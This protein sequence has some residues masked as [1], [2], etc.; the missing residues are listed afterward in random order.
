MSKNE[1]SQTQAG[2]LRAM[3]YNTLYRRDIPKKGMIAYM[4]N[5][6]G[7]RQAVFSPTVTALLNQGYI[8]VRSYTASLNEWS[9]ALTNMGTRKVHELGQEA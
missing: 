8:M 2:L 6:E 1:I 4:I 7:K 9:Y 5:G 3:Y